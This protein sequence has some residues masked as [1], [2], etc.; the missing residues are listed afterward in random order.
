M[1]ICSKSR[2]RLSI[3]IVTLI[4]LS[5]TVLAQD[6][7]A[8][9]PR[10]EPVVRALDPI[11]RHEMEVKQLPALSIALVDDQQVVWAAGFGL[12]DPEQKVPATA[13]TVYRV[14]SVS[15]LF[16]DLAVMKLA[17][18]GTLNIDAP[19][20]NYLPDFR[21]KNAFSKPITLRHLMAHRSGL[22][23]EPPVGNYFDP[24]NPS[25]ADMVASLNRTT[26]LLEPG[27]K[28]KYS[29]AGIA[30]VGYV[31]E[32]TQKQPFATYLR[33]NLLEPLGM[34]RSAFEPLPE[35][36]KDLAKATMS[37]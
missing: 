25:L 4:G 32:R 5:G 14:G 16:T 33:K 35:L 9:P 18:Q 17:E 13:G 11:I 24:T 26:V 27:A 3:A 6:S 1:A 29:N 20:G 34:T 30:T 15:K 7:I 8:P 21:P 23:R 37:T 22:V 28:T 19:V 36:T 2:Q 31:L 10:L 12:R